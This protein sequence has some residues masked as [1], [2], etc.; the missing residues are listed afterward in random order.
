MPLK[1]KRE[2]SKKKKRKNEKRIETLA[3]RD[4]E[5]QKENSRA[6]EELQEEDS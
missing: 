1:C 4:A 2:K 6:R 3:Q 5:A